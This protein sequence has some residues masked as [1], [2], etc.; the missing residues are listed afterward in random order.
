MLYEVI[1]IVLRKGRRSRISPS[2]EGDPPGSC[3]PVVVEQDLPDD[4]FRPGIPESRNVGIG[5]LPKRVRVIVRNDLRRAGTGKV[6]GY[7]DIE[8][9]QAPPPFSQAGNE[10]G[11]PLRGQYGVVSVF[12]QPHVRRGWGAVHEVGV[13]GIRSDFH[14]VQVVEEDVRDVSKKLLPGAVVVASYNFV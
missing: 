3:D 4:R 14:L 7:G 9:K 1:T 2:D 13:T 8:G 10:D 5:D 11:L 6:G 12:V